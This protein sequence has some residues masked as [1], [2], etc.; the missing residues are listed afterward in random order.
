M[1]LDN[2]ETQD[3]SKALIPG[4]RGDLKPGKEAEASIPGKRGDS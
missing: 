4:K 2:Y 1:I 3:K